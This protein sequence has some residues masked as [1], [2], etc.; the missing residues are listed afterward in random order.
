MSIF[1]CNAL[2]CIFMNNQECKVR[3]EIININSN[4]PLFYPHRISANECSGSYDNI[5]DL[6]AKLCVPDVVKSIN[7]RVF[8]RE[9]M[10]Q[11]IK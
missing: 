8:N 4:Q 5:N 11:D 10:K 7:V 3:P 2:K 1:S 9:I 6:Y